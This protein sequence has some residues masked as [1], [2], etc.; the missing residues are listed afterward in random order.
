MLADAC[1]GR[2]RLA[3]NDYWFSYSVHDPDTI[4]MNIVPRDYAEA[5][6][7]EHGLSTHEQ[8]NPLPGSKHKQ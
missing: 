3:D 1:D 2:I 8:F 6:L 7:N 5:V 4:E